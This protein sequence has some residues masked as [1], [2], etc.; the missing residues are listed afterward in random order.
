MLSVMERKRPTVNIEGTDFLFDIEDLVLIEKNNPGNYI[1]FG[2]MRDYGTHYAFTYS[3]LSKNY[4]FVK[5]EDTFFETNDDSEISDH[6]IKV[7]IPRIGVI[8]P[9]GMSRKYGYSLND[10]ALK[11]DFEIMVDQK[12][13]HDRMSGMPVTI[14]FP[15][16][17][18]EVDV[19]KNLLRPVDGIGE[20]IHLGA[21]EHDYYLDGEEVYHLYYDIKKGTVVDPI[22]DGS[23]DETKDRVVVEIPQLSELDPI[24]RNIALGW[25]PTTGLLYEDMKM[26]HQVNIVPWTD[27]GHDQS[28]EKSLKLLPE[29]DAWLP[30]NA[31]KLEVQ[32]TEQSL[33][34]DQ[35]SIESIQNQ[36][37]FMERE[38]PIINIKGTRFVVDVQKMELREKDHAE[39]CISFFEMRDL[40]N[41]Q[42]YSFSYSLAEKNIPS[43]WNRKEAITV[44]IPEMVTLD[45]EGMSKRYGVPLEMF[46]TKTDFD[47]M[48]DQSALKERLSGLLPI[49]DIEG[50]PFYV[51]IRMDMLRPKDDFMSKGIQFSKIED[52][53]VD[54]KEKYLVPYN[55]KTH[56]FQEVDFSKITDIPKDIIMVSFPHESKLDPIGYNRM[57]GF[58]EMSSLK[59]TNLKSHFKAGQVTW[60]ETGIEEVIKENKAKLINKKTVEPTPQKK[61]K[62]RKL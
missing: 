59:E 32:S 42:G 1:P 53:Y 5:T 44:T 10:I 13:F 38:L 24:G 55:P 23:W 35:S 22:L 15:G 12:A 37:N 30:K 34:V 9:E 3:A 31:D 29:I 54:E 49:V 57:H 41:H 19:A 51:D 48:V 4:H 28:V 47:L 8:D 6:P 39:N 58:D 11:S 60:K 52:Y 46:A 50:H 36:Q 16:R 2:Y 43:L 17:R 7:E 21:F 18:F 14:E 25:S 40:E 27:Y 26:N 61:R 20:Y 33:D 56:E 45:P 62:G